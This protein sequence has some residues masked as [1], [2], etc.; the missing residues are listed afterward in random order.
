MTPAFPCHRLVAS[1]KNSLH[2]SQSGGKAAAV[3]AAWQA[4]LQLRRA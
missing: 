4:A 2:D 1:V 3:P